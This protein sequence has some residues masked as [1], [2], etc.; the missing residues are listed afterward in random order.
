MSSEPTLQIPP[1]WVSTPSTTP[2]VDLLLAADW[3]PASGFRPRAMV[4]HDPTA[5]SLAEFQSQLISTYLAA[6]GE[7]DLE[8]AEIYPCPAR[9]MS[10]LRLWHRNDG[11]DLM[12]EARTWLVDGVAWTIAATVEHTD[13]PDF[14]DLFDELLL[15][16]PDDE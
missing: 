8:E 3:L 12:T 1:R 7:A 14:A 10:Y 2:R 13:Y 11:Y 5:A 15:R 6:L 9:E 4:A 16:F